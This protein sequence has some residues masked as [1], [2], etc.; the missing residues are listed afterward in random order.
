MSKNWRLSDLLNFNTQFTNGYNYPDDSIVISIFMAPGFLT[1]SSGLLSKPVDYFSI[2]VTLITVKGIFV[3]VQNLAD[4]GAFDVDKA[5][6]DTTGNVIPGTGK[7]SKL[8]LGAFAEL[9]FKNNSK[10]TLSFESKLNL[11]YNYLQDNHIAEGVTSIDFHWHNF[12]NYHVGKWFSINIFVH[13]ANM[14]GDVLFKRKEINC[15]LIC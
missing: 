2:L 4:L 7:T 13:F 3:L 12:V 14:P 6:T 15:Y 11:F 1:F 5:K 8:K 9:Y 10:E